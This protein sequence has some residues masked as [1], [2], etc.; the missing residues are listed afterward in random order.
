M[1][2]NSQKKKLL[3]KNH[4]ALW[5]VFHSCKRKGALD[6]AIQKA[7]VNDI[8]GLLR[9]YPHIKTIFLNS[10]TAQ[11]LFQNKFVET[12]TIPTHY[13][14]STSPAHSLKQKIQA[15]SAILKV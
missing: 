11:K 15:W 7:K 9:R 3:H 12:I 1:K 4:I 10:R 2:K 6:S 8:P 13:L 14:P 5:D